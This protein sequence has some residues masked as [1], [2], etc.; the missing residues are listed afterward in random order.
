[1]T[2]TTTRRPTAVP[3][4]T[5]PFELEGFL[6][7]RL[8][9][10]SNRV[11]R[12]IAQRYSAEFGLSIPEWRIMA[13]VGDAAPLSS[14]AICERTAMDKAKVSRAV[15]RLTAAGLLLRRT[16]PEDQRLIRLSLSR[17]G[18]AIYDKIVPR[19]RALEAALTEALRP[20]ERRQLDRLLR[21]LDRRVEELAV[22]PD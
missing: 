20:E 14:N 11:S 18:R 15:A 3:R 4:E 10:V 9:V 7:Y 22:E 13:V 5:Q 12:A 1:M 16:E 6:P 21:K 17:K 8:S 19:A 2:K